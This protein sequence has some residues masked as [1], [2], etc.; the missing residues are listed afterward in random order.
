MA[1][2]KFT[3]AQYTGA[4]KNLLPRGRVWS[5]ENSGIQHG[6][7]EGLAKSFQQMD[8]D[9]V[10]LLVEAFP[11][12]TTDLIDEWNATV[13]IP[14]F[15]FGAPETIEQNRQYIVAKLIADGGQTVDYYKSIAASLGLN[16]V[17]REF[18]TDHYDGDAPLGLINN[19]EDWC[20]TWKVVVDL[21]SPSLT[22][23]AGNETAIRESAVF[24]ALSCLMGRY[25]PAHT[26]FYITIFDFN[27]IDED[28][29]FGFAEAEED[30]EPFG[31]GRFYL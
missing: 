29:I 31:Q 6:L 23:F 13:G 28:P 26:Q 15:C 5:R 18:S 22:E 14:D 8:K 20:H 27:E 3:L 17:I 1:E 10:Q 19:P 9:A 21:N 25:K 16:T 24:K 4:L 30:A 2:S 11:S 12:S 7:I